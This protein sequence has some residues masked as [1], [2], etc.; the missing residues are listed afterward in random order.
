[1][2]NPD[3]PP[4]DTRDAEEHAAIAAILDELPPRARGRAARTQPAPTPSGSRSLVGRRDLAARLTQAFL[5]GNN[6]LLRLSER[7][8]P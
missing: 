7:F 6:R 1:M 3:K 2:L 8:K 4:P 5:D